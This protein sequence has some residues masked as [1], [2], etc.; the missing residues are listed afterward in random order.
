M[1]KACLEAPIRVHREHQE[2]CGIE[3]PERREAV[4]ENFEDP[5]R[6]PLWV[7]LIREKESGKKTQ[8]FLSSSYVVKQI[9]K[10]EGSL[11]TDRES[12]P[13]G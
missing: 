3:W 7:P 2:R 10:A 12:S 6:D 5:R 13:Y 1:S 11:G 9:R 4:L 8:L